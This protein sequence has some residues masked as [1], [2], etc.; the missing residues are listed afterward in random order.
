MHAGPTPGTHRI[1]VIGALGTLCLRHGAATALRRV[2]CTIDGATLHL[3]CRQ[4]VLADPIEDKDAQRGCLARSRQL[5]RGHPHVSRRQARQA[6]T[7][8][9]AL[10]WG[11]GLQ[12]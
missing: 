4:S 11:L 3:I 6:V 8:D 10:R 9:C 7:A 1:S 2:A 12:A 5:Q